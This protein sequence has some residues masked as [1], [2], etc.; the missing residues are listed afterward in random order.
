ML[1]FLIFQRRT[2]HVVFCQYTLWGFCL[3]FY[4]DEL[5]G[6]YREIILNV[7]FENRAIYKNMVVYKMQLIYKGIVY[8]KNYT[9][10]FVL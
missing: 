7:C 5:I 1:A 4:C 10:A 9:L 2:G 3:E 8:V 6:I